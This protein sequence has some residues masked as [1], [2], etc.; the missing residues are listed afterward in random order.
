MARVDAEAGRER[1]RAGAPPEALSEDDQWQRYWAVARYDLGLSSDEFFDCTPRQLDALIKRHERSKQEQEFLFAQ[2]TSC[3]VNFSMAG[4][5]KPSEPKDFM[6]S[7]WIKHP[8]ATFKRRRKRQL[9]ATEL[10]N[11]MQNWL[12]KD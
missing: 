3:V 10:R 5:K 11:V 2:L 6:P 9:I 7:E 1:R 4:P 8:V 12:R